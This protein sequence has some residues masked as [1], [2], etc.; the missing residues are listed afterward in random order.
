VGAAFGNL[1]GNI[2]APGYGGYIGSLIGGFA[3]GVC[4]SLYTDYLLVSHIQWKGMNRWK[5]QTKKN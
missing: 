3:F 2:L 4:S 5:C 1:I